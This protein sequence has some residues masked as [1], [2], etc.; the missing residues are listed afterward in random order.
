MASESRSVRQEAMVDHAEM[1]K[2][3][4]GVMVGDEGQE[5]W[6]VVLNKAFEKMKEGGSGGGGGVG[7]SPSRLQVRR[8]SKVN[9]I[10]SAAAT[11]RI[12]VRNREDE[13]QRGANDDS[14]ERS[15]E[16]VS[17]APRTKSI[18]N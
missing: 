2:D 17:L 15:D 5:C 11:M 3:H 14:E 4:R 7:S 6:G 1:L 13:A 10:I 9:T 16:G 8:S 18:L 12:Q